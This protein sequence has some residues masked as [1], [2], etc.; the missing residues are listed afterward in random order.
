MKMETIVGKTRK[1][2]D[3]VAK[4]ASE[5]V[6]PARVDFTTTTIRVTRCSTKWC[7]RANSGWK[8]ELNDPKRQ[9]GQNGKG[10]GDKESVAVSSALKGALPVEW[11]QHILSRKSGRRGHWKCIAFRRSFPFLCL[12]PFLFLKIN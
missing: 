4:F 3:L 12:L 7:S 10:I 5:I 2:T 11:N 1:K 6:T 8:S 9:Q